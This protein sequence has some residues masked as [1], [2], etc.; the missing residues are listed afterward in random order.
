MNISNTIEFKSTKKNYRVEQ[1]GLK[2]NTVRI[3]DI[4]EQE[5]LESVKD[6]LNCIQITLST[7]TREYFRRE[8]TNIT[9]FEI[10]ELKPNM[11]YI[12]SWR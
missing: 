9:E 12:F 1:A 5:D 2:P 4:N 7:D 3:L 11:L 6:R 8:L 10:E